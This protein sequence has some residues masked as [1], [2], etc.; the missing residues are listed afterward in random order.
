[1]G[2]TFHFFCM[3]KRMEPNDWVSH[4]PIPQKCQPPS[5]PHFP[6]PLY[7]MNDVKSMMLL[8]H[9]V[10]MSDLNKIGRAPL[11]NKTF[12]LSNSSRS[13]SGSGSTPRFSPGHSVQDK[14]PGDSSVD[15]VRRGLLYFQRESCGKPAAVTLLILCI[16]SSP[17]M[18]TQW[19]VVLILSCTKAM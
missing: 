17:L 6:P 13:S 10:W 16:N 18:W 14:D 5:S 8:S 12:L 7:K 15:W 11:A 19:R 2:C 1:M 9:A 3:K 4:L